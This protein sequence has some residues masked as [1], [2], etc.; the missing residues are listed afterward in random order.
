MMPVPDPVTG[1]TPPDKWA[2]LK[3][4]G[5][6]IALFVVTGAFPAGKSFQRGISR[7]A[8]G[9]GSIVFD[10]LDM[11]GLRIEKPGMEIPITLTKGVVTLDDKTKPAGPAAPRPAAVQRRNDPLRG[12]RPPRSAD[13]ARPDQEAPASLTDRR[14]RCSRTSN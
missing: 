14:S 10:L 8:F 2:D 3:V 9:H 6:G 4:A 5:R 13:H 11:R 1:I 12:C 7:G